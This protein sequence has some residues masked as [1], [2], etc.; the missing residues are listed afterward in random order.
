VNVDLGLTKQVPFGSRRL[1]FRLE[2][3]NLL[4]RANLGAPN[5]TVMNGSGVRNALAGFI[6]STSTTARQVQLGLRLDW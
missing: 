5:T 2:V 3:F 6:D 4:N 1:Q